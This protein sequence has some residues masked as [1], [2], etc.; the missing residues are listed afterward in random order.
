MDDL[1][2]TDNLA[3]YASLLSMVGGEHLAIPILQNLNARFPDNT[4][5]LN[6]LGQAWYGLGEMS[7]ARLCFG[8]VARLAPAHPHAN[9]TKSDIDQT[10]GNN[11]ES[12]E[13][14]KRSIKKEYSPDKEV[15]LEKKGVKLKHTDIDDPECSKNNVT[16]MRAAQLGFEKF[17]ALIP[18]YPST[19]GIPAQ[20]LHDE[21]NDLRQKISQAKQALDK[22]QLLLANKAEN[23]RDR[24]IKNSSLL[25]PYNNTQYLTAGRKL[26]LLIE[27][28]SE[29]L[30]AIS[31]KI[32]TAGDTISKWKKEYYDNI[33]K[34]ESCG[35][36]YSLATGFNANANSLWHVRNNELIDFYQEYYNHQAKL[37]LCATTD[38]SLYNLNINVL[39]ANFL[40]MLMNL[41]CEFEVGCIETKP[42]SPMGKVLPDYD[43]VN[44]QYKTELSI[45]YAEKYFSIKVECNRMTTKFDAKFIKGSLEENLANGKY[46]GT[47]EIE[48]KIGSDKIPVG[49]IEIGTQVKAGAG[50]DFT[51]GGIQDVYVTGEAGVK[52][53]QFTAGSVE[54]RVSVITGNTSVSGKGAFSGIS[55]R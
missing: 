33:A 2:N 27:W 36:R 7:N 37:F 14:L 34:A 31:K 21:W 32:M 39:K 3:N 6:N 23:Y 5:I 16:G 25:Q 1:T 28:G 26:A 4:T 47:V 18:D 42:N 45:P 11:D 20:T 43:E 40:I 30:V 38:S 24:V 22:E 53:G 17:V 9:E 55:I 10:E 52:T 46:K 41:H 12:I 50:V 15:K 49:P 51:E 44:C 29:R 8:A 19:G 35:G 13:E 54:A 48:A